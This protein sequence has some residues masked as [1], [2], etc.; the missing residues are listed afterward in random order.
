M[1]G[2]DGIAGIICLGLSIAML[3]MTRGLPQ[4]SLVPIGPDF[5]PRIVLGV[6]ALLSAILV[7][8]DVV[9]TLRSR[10]AAVRAAP[11]APAAEKNYKLV[12]LTFVLFTLY[13]ALLPWAGYRIA[14]FL[15][16][17]AQQ[18]VLE[19]PSTPRRWII[20]LITAAATSLITHLVFE[21]YLQVLL[22][23]GH[24]TGV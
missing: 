17:A 5:Y 3:V 23:R 15:F 20:V 9:A 10:G 24:W 16:V 1:L 7:V 11:T 22:P 14:T 8:A 4:S 21:H 2:R 12:V 13:V 19:P 18:V 6:A